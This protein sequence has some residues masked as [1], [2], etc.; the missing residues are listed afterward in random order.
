MDAGMERSIPE[1][2][3]KSCLVAQ[4]NQNHVL[5]P[6][7]SIIGDSAWKRNQIPDLPSH[8]LRFQGYKQRRLHLADV[9]GARPT[10][11]L[12][13]HRPS[14]LAAI[15]LYS[16]AAIGA[17]RRVRELAIV[18][19]AHPCPDSHRR[20]MVLVFFRGEAK[21]KKMNDVCRGID[22]GNRTDIRIN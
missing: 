20:L 16:S 2:L 10:S 8:R 21:R 12:F 3:S 9:P 1:E 7:N 4:W 14:V 6:Q 17:R 18:L 11:L 22:I 15:L 5:C 13:I 19:S